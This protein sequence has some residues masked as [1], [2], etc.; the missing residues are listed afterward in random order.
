M[1]TRTGNPSGKGRAKPLGK[2]AVKMAEMFQQ[3]PPAVQ[4][5]LADRCP[6]LWNLV[7]AS[8]REHYAAEGLGRDADIAAMIPLL[9]ML[10]TGQ[11][12]AIRR[13][14]EEAILDGTLSESRGNQPVFALV[15]VRTRDD[16]CDPDWVRKIVKRVRHRNPLLGLSPYHLERFIGA[17][18]GL[19]PLQVNHFVE[20]I[21]DTATGR[22]GDFGGD[23]DDG[24]DGDGD[25]S[26]APIVP[27][28]M[29]EA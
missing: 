27:A 11:T 14:I 2:S 20:A 16:R 18:E 12:K 23:D 4:R 8:R 1:G 21:V 10:E 29:S 26:D 5:H 17:M 15:L 22:G 9:A 7:P 24:D 3:L 25:G 6:A 19:T 13:A 28:E